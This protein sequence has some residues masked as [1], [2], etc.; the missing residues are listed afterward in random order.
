MPRGMTCEEFLCLEIW[1]EAVE[2][3]IKALLRHTKADSDESSELT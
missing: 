2:P 1:K 3:C